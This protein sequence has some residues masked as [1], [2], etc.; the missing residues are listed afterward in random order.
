MGG[1]LRIREDFQGA[2]L[3]TN[4]TL[5][6]KGDKNGVRGIRKNWGAR[7]FK[8]SAGTS[9]LDFLDYEWLIA[10]IGEGI[11]EGELLAFGCLRELEIFFLKRKFRPLT[12]QEC[13]IHICSY[14][15]GR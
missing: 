5:G 1:T 10:S 3:V 14:N 13:G 7:K 4:F 11:V 2:V 8:L 9:Y 15:K 12:E 6:I